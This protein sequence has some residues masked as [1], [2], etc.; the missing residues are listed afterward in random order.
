MI[1]ELPSWR[2]MNDPY[3][4]AYLARR[5]RAGKD[6]REPLVCG[7]PM[8]EEPESLHGKVYLCEGCNPVKKVEEPNGD[9]QVV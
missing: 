5:G 7:L 6:C 2:E 8:A 1:Y 3:Y 9:L 4:H